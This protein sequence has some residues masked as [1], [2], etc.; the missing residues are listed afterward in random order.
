MAFPGIFQKLFANGGAGPQLRPELVPL[1][2]LADGESVTVQNGKLAAAVKPQNLSDKLDL[3]RYAADAWGRPIAYAR[4]T[5]S[6][7]IQ[8]GIGFFTIGRLG[9][10]SFSLTYNTTLL[11][12]HRKLILS[13]MTIAYDNVAGSATIASN[14]TAYVRCWSMVGSVLTPCDVPFVLFIY[15]EV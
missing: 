13:V 3:S 14:G 7:S 6:C 15:Q 1:G 11:P 10:G 5:A 12:D 2:E 9:A 8:S 4:C